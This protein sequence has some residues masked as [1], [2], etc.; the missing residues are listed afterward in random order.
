MISLILPTSSPSLLS[1]LLPSSVLAPM[2]SGPGPLGCVADNGV[3][4]VERF[5][6]TLH[7]DR[8]VTQARRAR[9]EHTLRRSC[10]RN[11]A[12]AGR[13]AGVPLTPATAVPRA[14]TH[15]LRPT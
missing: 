4:W 12:C 7:V 5:M 14:R 10:C 8:Y 9:E 1:T 6:M 13:H 2:T 15:S 3:I 11:S